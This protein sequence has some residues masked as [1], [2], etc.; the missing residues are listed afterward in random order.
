M[1]IEEMPNMPL[2]YYGTQDFY[3]KFITW[4]LNEIKTNYNEI[5]KDGKIDLTPEQISRFRNLVLAYYSKNMNEFINIAEIESLIRFLKNQ[6]RPNVRDVQSPEF[7][8]AFYEYF[9]NEA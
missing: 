1:Y 9:I 8:S 2:E 5:I 6:T 7:K 4:R 3:N